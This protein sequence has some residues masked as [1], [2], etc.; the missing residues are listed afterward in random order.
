MHAASLKVLCIWVVIQLV[1]VSAL[2][3]SEPLVFAAVDDSADTIVASRVL[4]QAYATLGCEV[5]IRFYSAEDALRASNAGLAD[6]ELQRVDGLSSK[7]DKLIQIDIPINYIQGA[8]FSL[9]EEVKISNWHEL[10]PFRIGIVKGIVFSERGTRNMNRTMVET[11]P[12]LIELLLDDKVDFI[13]APMINGLTEI[14]KG[15]ASGR[16]KLNGVV[17]SML[18]YHYLH[19]SHEDLV[20]EIERVLKTMLLSGEITEARKKV[21]DAL[22][23]GSDEESE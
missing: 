6:G 16:V 22:V 8:V 11:Y 13:I 10:R 3:A 19:K 7:Y 9:E 4:K 20:P 18:L 2:N 5:S 21:L 15:R 14:Q 17:E 23:Q 12:E 1:S